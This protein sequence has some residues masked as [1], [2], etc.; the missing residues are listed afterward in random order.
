MNRS[1]DVF[2]GYWGGRMIIN[3][4]IRISQVSMRYWIP[5][6]IYLHNL[7][8]NLVVRSTLDSTISNDSGTKVAV[9]SQDINYRFSS[10]LRQTLDTSV[11]HSREVFCAWG[12]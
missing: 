4:Q 9:Y 2:A 12:D 7:N 1:N 11:L 6:V 5:S 3:T 8:V 10:V